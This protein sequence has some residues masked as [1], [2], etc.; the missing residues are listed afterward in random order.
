[1]NLKKKLVSMMKNPLMNKT[2][3]KCTMLK[4]QLKP[5]LASVLPTHEKKEMVNFSHTDSLM[6]EN[7]D[8]VDENIDTLYI[9]GGT[10]GTWVVSFFDGDPIYDIEGTFQVKNEK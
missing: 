8:V 10:Y 3:M 1:M 7:L 4:I 9:L 2:S 5:P 6:R